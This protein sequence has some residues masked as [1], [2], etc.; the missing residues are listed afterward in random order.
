[1]RRET[2]YN[3]RPSETYHAERDMK[4]FL[5]KRMLCIPLGI[6][7]LIATWYARANPEWTEQ[8]FSR[9]VYPAL[10]SAVG[11]LPSLVS[12]SV[13]EWVAVLFLL[14]CLGYIAYYVRKIVKGE[15][16]RSVP[17]TQGEAAKASSG[18]RGMI[19]YR[20]IMGAVAICC[21]VYFLFTFLCGLNYYRY[22]FTSYTGYD[23]EQ[24]EQG[25]EERRDELVQLCTT[26]ADGMGQA[27]EELG[28]DTDLY[29][30][31]PG[32]FERYA[33]ESVSAIEELAE[34]YPVLDRPLYSPPKPVL[35]SGLLSDMDIGGIFVP[36]TME[37]NINVDGPF[38]TIPSTMAHELAHQCGFMR[39]DEA[40]FIAYLACKESDDPL[41]RYSGY[42]L[43]FD[44]SL[45]ALRKVDPEAASAIKASLPEAVLHDMA[46]REHF[47]AEHEGIVSDV[48]NAVNDTY[49]KANNQTH[50]VQSYGRMVELLLAEQRAA[51]E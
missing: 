4:K 38:F 26:L 46:Q 33:H 36:F 43:A 18:G 11:F 6:V 13:A 40:N 31:D 41:M 3:G 47:W 27:R 23:V 29:T 9:S 22:T 15:G 10:S 39:E 2:G 50:G 1:M 16:G 42:L 34:Q 8:V 32:D 48:S 49:L 44:R 28:S 20:G 19:A 30:A 14:F 37:S 12:F 45:A 51:A 7:A 24:S 25:T 21:V 5:L 35:M 17:S